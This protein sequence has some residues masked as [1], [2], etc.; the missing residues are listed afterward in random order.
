MGLA[1]E[2]LVAAAAMDRLAAADARIA[3]LDRSRPA[4]IVASTLEAARSAVYRALPPDTVAFGWHAM[5]LELLARRLAV[6]VL[7]RDGLAPVS[8]AGLHAVVARVL[9]R[10]GAGGELGRYQGLADK[11]GLAPAIAR[12]LAELRMC[13][14]SSDALEGP[15]R[16]WPASAPSTRRSSGAWA[17]PIAPACWPRRCARSTRAPRWSTARPA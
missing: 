17:W 11:P 3:Q 2:L 16:T 15:R 14:V 6:P 4:L 13:R 7:A 10:L 12:T 8:G 9:G 1:R 5:T